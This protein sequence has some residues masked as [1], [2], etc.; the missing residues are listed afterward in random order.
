MIEKI[1][2][3]FFI[4]IFLKKKNFLTKLFFI[5]HLKKGKILRFIEN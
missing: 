3:F 2:K 4:K 1:N 5:F